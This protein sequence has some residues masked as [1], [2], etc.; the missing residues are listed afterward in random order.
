MYKLYEYRQDDVKIGVIISDTEQC[1]YIGNKL[2]S[3]RTNKTP[4]KQF[5]HSDI[6]G[7]GLVKVELDPFQTTIA[8]EVVTPVYEH[9]EP[10]K[11]SI[12][13]HWYSRLRS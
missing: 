1:L 9:Q 13:Q 12:L 10:D 8:G 7:R 2:Y 5:L 4:Y 3:A 11:A 6:T